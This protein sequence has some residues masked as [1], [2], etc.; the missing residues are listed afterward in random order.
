M[1][2]MDERNEARSMMK[3]S[4]GDSK[5]DKS[6]ELNSSMTIQ[7]TAKDSY[8]QKLHSIGGTTSGN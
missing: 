7:D 3:E 5:M 2:R 6:A 1:H 8:E 4:F